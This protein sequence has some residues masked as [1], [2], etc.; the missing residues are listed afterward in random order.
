MKK[1][2]TVL[3]AVI[4]SL[5]VS[6]SAFADDVNCII[7]INIQ[8][9]E[10][11]TEKV[12]IN[13]DDLA[14]EEK[15]QKMVQTQTE[16]ADASR[17]AVVSKNTV[18]KI[19]YY[20]DPNNKYELVNSDGSAIGNLQTNSDTLTLDLILR[21]RADYKGNE[22]KTAT[23]PKS[24]KSNAEPSYVG[25]T[26][27]EMLADF[28][29]RT[30][31]AESDPAYE[32]PIWKLYSGI[33]DASY[34]DEDIDIPSE[35]YETLT[36]YDKARYFLVHTR[37]TWY[38]MGESKSP[39]HASFI[40]Q[41]QYPQNL[42]KNLE[43]GDEF[44]NAMLDVWEW[45]WKN[46]QEKHTYTSIFPYTTGYNGKFINPEYA[47]KSGLTVEPETNPSKP[48]KEPNPEPSLEDAKKDLEE[49]MTKEEIKQIEEDFKDAANIDKYNNQPD[50]TPEK[51]KS[52]FKEYGGWLLVI[53]VAGAIL[54]IIKLKN[55]K[56]NY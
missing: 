19:T 24:D 17:T 25:K 11:L 27:E 53:I 13:F 7:T 16:G 34:N 15:N 4:F 6:V 20:I 44:Y 40:G 10:K 54:L 49:G 31:F 43:G 37:V 8:N 14:I 50:K 21:T 3:L 36:K 12:S 1:L 38:I 55:R 22:D 45:H 29:A 5:I 32:Q 28:V 47:A 39:N 26:P 35:V 2:R 51:S 30:K 9:A 48:P 52:F 41:L 23:P 56:K 33:V 42:M 46:M 18:Y